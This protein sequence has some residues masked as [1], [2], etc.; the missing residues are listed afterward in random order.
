[1]FEAISDN[2]IIRVLHFKF[3]QTDNKKSPDIDSRDPYKKETMKN[4]VKT[5]KT[6]EMKK[7]LNWFFNS[8]VNT[9]NSESKD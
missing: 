5:L 4:P 6:D 8:L 3:M 2:T 9:H 7:G 1:M